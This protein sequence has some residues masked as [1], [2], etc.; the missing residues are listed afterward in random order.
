MA[1]YALG[2]LQGCFDSF[3]A[4]LEQI[5]FSDNDHL[6]LAGDLVNRG[7]KSLETLEFLMS[8]SSQVD[9]VLGNHDLHLLALAHGHGKVKRS[10]T[11]QS[12]LEHA[13]SSDII[14]WLS[15]GKLVSEKPEFNALMS[16]AG[17]P[18]MWSAEQALSYAQEVEAVIQGPKANH[19]F[20]HMYGNTPD[21]WHNNL[22][23]M[24]RWRAITNYL[25]RMRFLDAQFT[26][27]FAAKGELETAPA[28]FKPW[29]D[30][31]NP[32]L[33]HQVYFGHWAALEGYT[34]QAHATALD[35]GCVWGNSL[36]AL[37]LDDNKR[38]SQ[39]AID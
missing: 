10:D 2:D 9:F 30:Y 28:G 29:F 6:W 11:L 4:L 3:Q 13:K 5:N 25:T 14:D 31:H 33:K 1:T 37:R 24:D 26:L 27:E 32:H 18:P 34:G 36:T 19:Y 23:G 22:E 21:V 15:Q 20:K 39:A 7:P 35:T 8:I 17:I 38:F 12:I 16:H